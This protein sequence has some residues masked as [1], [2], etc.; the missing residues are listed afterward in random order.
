MRR[1]LKPFWVLLALLFLFEAWLWEKLQRAVAWL[2]RLLALPVLRAKLAAAIGRLPPWATLIVFVI[3]VLLLLPIKIAGLWMLAHGSWL[4]AMA[5]LAVAKIVSV[6]VT[7]FIFDAT[8]PKLLQMAWFRRLYDWIMRGLVWA[9]RLVDP[10]KEEVR[11][12]IRETTAPF[13]RWARALMRREGGGRF[14]RQ[15]R[16]LRRRTQRV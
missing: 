16:R 13:L 1:W 12:W 7:A 9:H 8:R 3:P 14:W 15:V 5:M 10:V 6:G 4:G 2:V 11:A